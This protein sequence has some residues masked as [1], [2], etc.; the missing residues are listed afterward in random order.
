[1]CVSVCKCV[2][3]EQFEWA[4]HFMYPRMTT[5]KI[6]GLVTLPQASALPLFPHSSFSTA[7]DS[8]WTLWSRLR[9]CRNWNPKPTPTTWHHVQISYARFCTILIFIQHLRFKWSWSC[10]CRWRW[11]W[12]CTQSKQIYVSEWDEAMLPLNDHAEH[13]KHERSQQ[14]LRLLDL[15][16]HIQISCQNWHRQPSCGLQAWET[17]RQADRQVD[18][19]R[20]WQSQTPAEDAFN[21]SVT[22]QQLHRYL[23]LA[24]SIKKQFKALPK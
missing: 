20:G 6:S 12:R 17:D 1:M 8:N 4:T 18:K 13:E 2:W 14:Q 5:T 7:K 15:S 24:V 23:R 11:R 16:K 3:L 22:L 19:P 21:A 9:R 10:S